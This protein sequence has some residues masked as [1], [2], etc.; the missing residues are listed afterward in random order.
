M[1]SASWRAVTSRRVDRGDGRAAP[2]HGDL[3]GDLEHLV[4]LVRDE[5]DG[6]ALA[7][8]LA[9]VVE[10]LV[11]LLGHEHGGRLV[12][13]EDAGA[14]VEHLEDLDPLRS[15]TPSS[16]DEASGSTSGRRR[17]RARGCARGPRSRCRAAC[18]ARL[19]RTTFSST[20]R[21]SAS[22]KC[23]CTMPMPAA[24]ASSGVA[25]RPRSPSTVIVPS[26][27]AASRRGSSSA[28]TCRRRSRRRWR[29]PCRAHREVDVVVGDHAGEPLGD[30]RAARR[31]GR[32]SGHR[33]AR[34]LDVGGCTRTGRRSG[35][36]RYARPAPVWN[37]APDA[38]V[39]APAGCPGASEAQGAVGTVDVAVDDL[40]L[41]LLELVVM[42]STKPPLVE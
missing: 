8:E 2:D 36:A 40:L 6:H 41:E 27:G 30:A 9:Q 26:S 18:S 11:D 21:L 22:M 39:P 1:S 37:R 12:E 28:S 14:P 4:E 24:M 23:W 7:L 13:D 31:R 25:A 29:G 17:R 19:P 33:R 10:E 38:P 42:S 5:D 35:G 32:V 3:V 20:V 34:P 15:P 16:L